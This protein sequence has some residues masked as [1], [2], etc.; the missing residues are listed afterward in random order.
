MS[1]TNRFALAVLALLLIGPASADGIINGGGSGGGSPTGAAGGDLS[2]TYPN[3]TYTGKVGGVLGQTPGTTTNDA[4][5]AGRI[6]EY[7]SSSV[8]VGSAIALTNITAATITSISLTAGDWDVTGTVLWNGGATTLVVFAN[9]SLSL[10]ANF[11][12]SNGV[13]ASA[14]YPS[15]GSAIFASANPTSLSVP[16]VRFS[17]SATTTIYLVSY[18]AFTTSTMS[19]YGTIHARRV[20]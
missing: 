6:G 16:P 5:S 11:D 17:L 9:A 12:A 14:G 18:C 8:V 19:A 2:G 7:V 1:I 20:R 4:A 3:P 15:G 13:V 10:V